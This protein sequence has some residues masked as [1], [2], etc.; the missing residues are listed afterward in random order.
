MFGPLDCSHGCTGSDTRGMEQAS[1]RKARQGLAMIVNDEAL[2]DERMRLRSALNDARLLQRRCKRNRNALDS[3]WMLSERM[4]RITSICFVACDYDS[5]GAAEYLAAAGRQRHWPAKSNA[6]LRSLAEDVFLRVD[7]STLLS[8]VD[9][10]EPADVSACREALRYAREYFVVARARH[11][12]EGGVAPSSAALLGWAQEFLWKFPGGCHPEALGTTRCKSSKKWLRKLRVRWK[13]KLRALPVAVPLPITEFRNKVRFCEIVRVIIL[14]IS[15]R[16]RP[17]W[18]LF[19]R[20][21]FWARLADL[22]F[23]RFDIVLVTGGNSEAR[24]V[25]H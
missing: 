18:R 6:A 9:F 21:S 4:I 11:A 3:E 20:P 2:L 17:L 10:E 23:V 5:G 19:S 1:A 24:S 12:N 13:G 15:L 22:K 7:L 16:F 14:F 8:W 25:A